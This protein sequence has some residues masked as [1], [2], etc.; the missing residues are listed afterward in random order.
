MQSALV[1]VAHPDDE[2]IWCGGLLLRNRKK[3]RTT[4]L[5]LCRKGDADRAPKFFRVCRHYGA[6]GMMSDLE[7]DHP[8]RKL[9]GLGEATGRI[10]SLLGKKRRFD[11]IITHGKNGEYGHSRHM[12]VRRAVLLLLKK[13][14]IS[15]GTLLSFSYKKSGPACAAKSSA[16]KRFPL[17]RAELREKKFLITT[18]YGFSAGGFEEKSCKQ[19][20]A[21]DEERF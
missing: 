18:L 12:E 3:W 17:S 15:C 16:R 10:L 7:D 19:I 8:Q 13:K 21:F 20:E 9:R 14:K 4:I 11:I 1:I 5:S 6:K 2:T